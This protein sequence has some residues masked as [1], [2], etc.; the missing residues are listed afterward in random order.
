MAKKQAIVQTPTE[1]LHESI[2]EA[3]VR[4][5]TT[6]IQAYSNGEEVDPLRIK[7]AFQIVMM[8]QKFEKM[9]LQTEQ[10]RVSNS[11]RVANL[12]RDPSAREEFAKSNLQ[13]GQVLVDTVRQATPR[14]R[15]SK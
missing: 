6:D 11:I 12:L 7:N 1:V 8:A 13:I 4:M 14:R 5:A 15:I 9:G 2:T 10:N 3:A